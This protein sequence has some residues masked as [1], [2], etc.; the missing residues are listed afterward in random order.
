MCDIFFRLSKLRPYLIR[1]LSKMGN[2]PAPHE[3]RP[4]KFKFPMGYF[5][6]DVNIWNNVNQAGRREGPFYV[7]EPDFILT[8][9]DELPSIFGTVKTKVAKYVQ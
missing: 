1:K 5:S 3:L 6:D 8:K 7:E 9:E 4:S 2:L